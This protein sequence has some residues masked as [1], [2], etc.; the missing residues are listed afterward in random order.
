MGMDRILVFKKCGSELA[1]QVAADLSAWSAS[2]NIEVVDG[3]TFPEANGQLAVAVPG[4]ARVPGKP[5]IIRSTSVDPLLGGIGGCVANDSA[6]SNTLAFSSKQAVPSGG[7]SPFTA[8]AAFS[9]APCSPPL[10]AISPASATP[11]AAPLAH[12]GP[13]SS[14]RPVGPRR[15]MKPFH[16]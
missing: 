3:Q 13:S 12:S 5:Q 6:G 16:P 9:L 4:N 14:P 2:R 7:A 8:M 1:D 15:P 11:S 10:A